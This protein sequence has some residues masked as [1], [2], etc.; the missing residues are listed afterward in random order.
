M[1]RLVG[2][3]PLQPW[4]SCWDM[5][6]AM[7]DWLPARFCCCVSAVSAGLVENLRHSHGRHSAR[8][9]RSC[10]NKKICTAGCCKTTLARAAATGSGAS[11]QALAGP[12]LYSAFLGEGEA[13]V[14]AA[15]L[16][17]RS[18][19]PAIIFLDELDALAGNRGA[20]GEAGASG[21]GVS[22]AARLLSVLLTEMDGMEHATGR[23]SPL[24]A[25]LHMGST[26]HLKRHACHLLCQSSLGL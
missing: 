2:A 4:H 3:P 7:R 5:V 9:Q 19:A 16:R 1:G 14:R 17:A 6:A 15:F 10:S 18:A 8:S 23:A 26:L 11:F 12:Q 22:T 13:A 25:T 20:V 24:L 21:S